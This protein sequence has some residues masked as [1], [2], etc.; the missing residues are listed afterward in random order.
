VT[1]NS[2]QVLAG[3]PRLFFPDA[4]ISMTEVGAILMLSPEPGDR[5][6]AG[7]FAP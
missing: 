5:G 3:E 7:P 4:T 6:F 2:R 1:G